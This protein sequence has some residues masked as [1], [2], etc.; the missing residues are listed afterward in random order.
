MD[1]RVIPSKQV[2]KYLKKLKSKKLKNEFVYHIYDTIA[3]N[4]FIGQQKR[5]DLVGIWTYGFRMDKVD[6]RIAYKI[7]DEAV[8]PIILCGAHENFYQELKRLK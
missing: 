1:Y 4:P 2:I 6:Y 3:Q 5:G 8:I 7:T